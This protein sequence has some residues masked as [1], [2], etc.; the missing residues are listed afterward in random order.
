MLSD[1]TIDQFIKFSQNGNFAI[2]K[3]IIQKETN[4]KQFENI[5]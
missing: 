5:C 4:A 1:K 2:R 3:K